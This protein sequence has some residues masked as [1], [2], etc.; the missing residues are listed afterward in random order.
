[1]I[2]WTMRKT[3]IIE[4]TMDWNLMPPSSIGLIPNDHENHFNKNEH[5]GSNWITNLSLKWLK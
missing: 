1:M 2:V 4:R 5:L 3:N